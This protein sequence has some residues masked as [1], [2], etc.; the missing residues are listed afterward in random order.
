MSQS[1][2]K[3]RLPKRLLYVLLLT[4]FSTSAVGLLADLETW[5]LL[6]AYVLLLLLQGGFFLIYISFYRLPRR[7]SL[8]L[9]G[10]GKTGEH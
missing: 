9:P 6:K 2:V 8:P 7:R 10:L 5:Y 3:P 4:L 1:S